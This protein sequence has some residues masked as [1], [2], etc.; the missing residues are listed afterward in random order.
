MKMN[1]K[2]WE[3]EEYG[4]NINRKEV[5]AYEYRYNEYLAIQ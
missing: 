1:F 5:E 2:Q 4:N 3:I